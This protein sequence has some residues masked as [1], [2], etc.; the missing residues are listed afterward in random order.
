MIIYIISISNRFVKP[1][2][3]SD[4]CTISYYSFYY[5]A[6]TNLDDKGLLDAYMKVH[7][8]E[9][10]DE[11]LEKGTRGKVEFHS[12]RSD[13]ENKQVM[14]TKRGTVNNPKGRKIHQS[15]AGKT[16]GKLLLNFVSLNNADF[17]SGVLDITSTCLNLCTG[18]RCHLEIFKPSSCFF[19]NLGKY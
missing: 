13:K 9:Q 5:L 8:G 2:I 6:I 1:P 3:C 10:I 17:P 7:E 16:I 15:P 18:G 4:M 14:K 19:K 12:G 11:I